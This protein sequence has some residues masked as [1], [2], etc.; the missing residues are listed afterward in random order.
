MQKFKNIGKSLLGEKYVE[1]KKKESR[2]NNA[3]FSSHY[4]RPR[5]H[6]VRA[7]ALRFHQKRLNLGHCPNLSDPP[8]QLGKLFISEKNHSFE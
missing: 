5:T 7:H 3:K 1:G 4:V 6:N 2:R 8:L